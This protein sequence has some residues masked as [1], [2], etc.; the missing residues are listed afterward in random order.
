[1]KIRTLFLALLLAVT[2]V[3]AVVAVADETQTVLTS[4][5]VVYAVDNSTRSE[6]RLIRRVGEE[7]QTLVVPSTEDP[8]FDTQ[9]HLL[10]DDA[11]SMLFV[12]WHRSH[13]RSD[14][15]V[16]TRLG[17]DGTWADPLLVATG[18]SAKRAGL[19]T[20][21]ARVGAGETATTLIHVAWWSINADPVAEYALM[22]FEQGQHLSTMVADLKTLAGANGAADNDYEPVT[23]V[24]H[25]PLA[26]ARSGA[27]GVDVV[28]GS[29]TSTILTRVILEPKV[30]GDARLWKPSRK[31]GGITPRAGL[32]SA[33]GDPVKAI[34]SHGRI[35]LYTPDEK[36]RFVMFNNGEWTPQRMIQLDE[37]LTRDAMVQELRRTVQELAIDED[38]ATVIE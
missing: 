24:L 1:V 3:T 16:M 36:F 27:A 33:N 20:V 5:G 26:M 34:L 32:M 11:T 12:V 21:L 8:A 9:A 13:D 4:D 19:Q 17:A 28:F 38:G 37:K 30:R 23:E 35:V 29:P 7:R 6:L 15:I 25:P 14:Q 10:W 31:G 22:A 18:S 2:A